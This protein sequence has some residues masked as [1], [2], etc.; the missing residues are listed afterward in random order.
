VSTARDGSTALQADLT[1]GNG[2]G[3]QNSPQENEV[4]AELM[5]G[6]VGTTPQDFPHWGSLLLGPA[7]RGTAVAIK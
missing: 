3:M 4:I 5:A 6:S 2:I 1:T 7:L